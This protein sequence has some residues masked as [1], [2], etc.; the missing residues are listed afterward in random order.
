MSDCL[1]ELITFEGLSTIWNQNFNFYSNYCVRMEKPLFTLPHVTSYAM[2]SKGWSGL[3]VT[4]SFRRFSNQSFKILSSLRKWK[5]TANASLRYLKSDIH[6]RLGNHFQKLTQSTTHQNL[7][8]RRQ[9]FQA[10]NKKKNRKNAIAN[11][12]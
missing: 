1:H 12:L 9:K 6:T 5:T 8:P 7:E 4:P 11:L 3:K 10:R 2:E